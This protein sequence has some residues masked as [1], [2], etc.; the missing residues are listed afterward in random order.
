MLDYFRVAFC[1]V[2]TSSSNGSEA[3]SSS[4]V[5]VCSRPSSLTMRT[6]NCK[7]SCR[8][9][10]PDSAGSVPRV[11]AERAGDKIEGV[12]GNARVDMHP[13]IV[14]ASFE[15]VFH[16]R[17]LRV[18]AKPRIVISGPRLFH[19]ANRDAIDTL[20]QQA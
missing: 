1:T 3:T 14:G 12:I 9:V 7:R 6:V 8:R 13:A 19:G 10:V 17:R 4:Q 5:T 15:I 20:G 2:R 18:F 16:L 11:A